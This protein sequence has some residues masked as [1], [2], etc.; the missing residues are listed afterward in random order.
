MLSAQVLSY[1]PMRGVS[2]VLFNDSASITD[3][4]FPYKSRNFYWKESNQVHWRTVLSMMRRNAKY[5]I[6]H[7]SH[8]FMLRW[9]CSVD[10]TWKLI[11]EMRPVNEKKFDETYE[12]YT[13]L[14]SSAFEMIHLNWARQTWNDVNNF[15]RQHRHRCWVLLS[16]VDPLLISGTCGNSYNLC[17]HLLRCALLCSSNTNC[18]TFQWYVPFTKKNISKLMKS[19]SKKISS[20]REYQLDLRY[21]IG[22]LSFQQYF[23]VWKI[24]YE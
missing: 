10:T 24:S 21:A 15:Q 9:Q 6:G 7:K 11:D 23:S 14:V 8:H 5:S 20:L 22:N 18:I 2:F 13:M 16:G 17:P 1:A 19:R 4:A 3:N 12:D